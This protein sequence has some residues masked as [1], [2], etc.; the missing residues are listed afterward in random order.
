MELNT[1][2]MHMERALEPVK[3][4]DGPLVLID[5]PAVERILEEL[6]KQAQLK[7]KFEEYAKTLAEVD[8]VSAAALA[9]RWRNS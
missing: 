2:I 6:Q 5:V 7:K 3:E 1:A 9:R 4:A 8:P